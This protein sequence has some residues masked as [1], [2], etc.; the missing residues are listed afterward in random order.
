MDESNRPVFETVKPDKASSLESSPQFVAVDKKK[1]I[2]K[3]RSAVLKSPNTPQPHEAR[4]KQKQTPV[5]TAG[6]NIALIPHPAKGSKSP[7]KRPA[8]ASGTRAFLH[9]PKPEPEPVLPKKK[10]P[11]PTLSSL[12]GA[13]VRTDK[14]PVTQ[15]PKKTKPKWEPLF[16]HAQPASHTPR[17][18]AIPKLNVD[19]ERIDRLRREN[20]Q[21]MQRVEEIKRE[22]AR[23][24]LSK[25]NN[26]RKE[27]AEE[28][29][30]QK[31]KKEELEKLAHKIQHFQKE[32]VKA[33]RELHIIEKQTKKIK[34]VKDFARSLSQ[35]KK[36]KEAIKAQE[37]NQRKEKV[38]SI[39]QLK[40]IGKTEMVKALTTKRE[41]G[42][43]FKHELEDL[44]SKAKGM[45]ELETETHR[46][47][48]LL[49]SCGPNAG[50]NS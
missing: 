30:R 40:E 32:N 45:N 49:V 21:L 43:S 9:H 6:H 46:N 19:Q 15:A 24:E 18:G 16:S 8:T 2:I 33:Q 28:L 11:V 42:I 31:E 12:P 39:R 36:Q 48:V 47:Q 13:S 14:S 4:A 27:K 5:A 25:E 35:I 38:A 1:E 37:E 22:N 50:Q 41:M 26:E 34:E 7:S 44:L 23:K 29:K 10:P 20:E 17:Q 3:E